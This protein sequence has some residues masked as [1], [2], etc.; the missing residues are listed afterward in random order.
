LKE[1]QQ[2]VKRTSLFWAVTCCNSWNLYLLNFKPFLRIL[3]AVVCDMFNCRTACLFE[4]SG[5]RTGATPAS[6]TWASATGRLRRAFPFTNAARLIKQFILI[7]ISMVV[8]FQTL[9]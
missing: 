7:D 9:Y 6:S 5:L 4:L 8:S 3:C 1:S 2:I